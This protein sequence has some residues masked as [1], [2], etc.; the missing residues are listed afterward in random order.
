MTSCRFKSYS[1]REIKFFFLSHLSVA[2]LRANVTE[3]DDLPFG[4]RSFR[5]SSRILA[6]PDRNRP[7]NRPKLVRAQFGGM[8]ICGAPPVACHAVCPD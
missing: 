1:S 5:I 7:E 2:S 8:I 3:A 4:A 6:I